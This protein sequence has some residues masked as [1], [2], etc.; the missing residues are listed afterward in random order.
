MLFQINEFLEVPYIFEKKMAPRESLN[1]VDIGGII[2]SSVQW[3]P[4]GMNLAIKPNLVEETTIK[5]EQAI[6]RSMEIKSPKAY[7]ETTTS[8]AKAIN[9]KTYEIAW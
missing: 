1:E 6:F 2:Y 4:E 9:Y 7:I 3:D 5:L 8:Y